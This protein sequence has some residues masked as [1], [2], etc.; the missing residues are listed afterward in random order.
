MTPKYTTKAE[1]NISFVS[2][3]KSSVRVMSITDR[4][5]DDSPILQPFSTKE[6]IENKMIVYLKD[7]TKEL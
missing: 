1:R 7:S 5:S 2:L 3:I 6:Y 4:F